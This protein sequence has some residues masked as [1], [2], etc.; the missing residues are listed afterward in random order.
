MID[1]LTDEERAALTPATRAIFEALGVYAEAI[2]NKEETGAIICL[3]SSESIGRVIGYARGND[4]AEM[5]CATMSALHGAASGLRWARDDLLECMDHGAPEDKTKK[6]WES[7]RDKVANDVAELMEI[8]NDPRLIDMP[9]ELEHLLDT[10]RRTV[11][12][13]LGGPHEQNPN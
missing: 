7:I 8:A 4:R 13:E 11:E 3:V 10:L 9:A 2:K 12:K 6:L 5:V 1:E